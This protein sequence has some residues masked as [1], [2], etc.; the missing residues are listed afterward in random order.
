MT[1]DHSAIYYISM[2]SGLA[3]FLVL[4]IGYATGKIL[5]KGTIYDKDLDPEDFRS[6]MIFY[7]LLAFGASLVFVFCLIMGY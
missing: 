7:W 4:I 1:K 6:Y 2:I 5:S 3:S